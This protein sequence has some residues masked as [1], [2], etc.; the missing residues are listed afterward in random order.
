MRMKSE[1]RRSREL[2][3]PEIDRLALRAFRDAMRDIL[4]DQGSFELAVTTG[5]E[6]SI[7]W[8]GTPRA[9]A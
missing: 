5:P 4:A 3:E 2:H 6:A 9:S 7:A 1:R 8:H